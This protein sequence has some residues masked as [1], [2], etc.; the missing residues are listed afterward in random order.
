M[1]TRDKIKKLRA[2]GTTIAC[3][4]LLFIILFL[5]FAGAFPTG[6]D[7]INITSNTTGQSGSGMMVNISGGYIAKMNITA[8]SQNNRWKAMIGEIDGKFTLDDATGSTIYDW[9]STVVNGE[10]YATRQSGAITWSSVECANITHINQE[11]LEMSLTGED[12]IS[13]T[14]ND[15]ND[16]TFQIGTSITIGVTDCFSTNTYVGNESQDAAFEE[17][18]LYD[19]TSIIFATILETNEEGY[20]GG[21]YDFQ[22]IVPENATT[23]S[24][25]IPYYLY[26]EIGS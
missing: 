17:V 3:C 6:P 8:T 14:F 4:A 16:E 10:V 13:Q 26:L 1:K 23:G 25:Q 9:T 18:V 20:D 5:A 11:D 24:A 12:N 22:M 15:T 21:N 7:A 2:G 19:S